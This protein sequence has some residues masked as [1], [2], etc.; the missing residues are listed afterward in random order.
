MGEL[1]AWVLCELSDSR[2][3]SFFYVVEQRG[4]TAAESTWP[5]QGSSGTHLLQSASG[6][7]F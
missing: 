3:G 1:V 2:I 4:T 7:F 5:R 6:P